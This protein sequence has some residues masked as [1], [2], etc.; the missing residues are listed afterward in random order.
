MRKRK[1]ER[2]KQKRKR[3]RKKKGHNNRYKV[4]VA[5]ASSFPN[6]D[7]FLLALIDFL[8]FFSFP[9]CSCWFCILIIIHSHQSQQEFVKNEEK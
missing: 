4:Y 6:Y 7:D 8:P 1:R 2:E 9:I 5:T 3:E